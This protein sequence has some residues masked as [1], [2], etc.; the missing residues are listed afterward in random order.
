LAEE[1]RSLDYY[2]GLSV[3]A[4][5]AEIKREE[6]VLEDLGKRVDEIEDTIKTLE[7]AIVRERVSRLE[8]RR[9]IRRETIRKL[10]RDIAEREPKIRAIETAIPELEARARRIDIS[11]TDRHITEREI[12][13]LKRSLARYRWW[14]E[15]KRR[16]LG[17][18]RRWQRERVDLE[19]RLRALNESLANWTRERAEASASITHVR[20]ELEK[21]R[22]A[23]PV[24]K[25]RLVE[26]VKF[27]DVIVRNSAKTPDISFELRGT[28]TIPSG[29]DPA[30][31]R[32]LSVIED[33][34]AGAFAGWG[35]TR[36]V[37]YYQW[38]PAG[39][40]QRYE[41]RYVEGVQR[42]YWFYT[43]TRTIHMENYEQREGTP[44]PKYGEEVAGETDTFISTVTVTIAKYKNKKAL[45][46]QTWT[47]SVTIAEKEFPE[48]PK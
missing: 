12:T 25:F 23:L 30:D 40:G 38:P 13:S 37:A 9:A 43:G 21:K 26:Y 10:E 46:G 3:Q 34:L 31:P 18:Y 20:M 44:Y 39:P 47:T 16:S 35:A 48:V 4:L 2:K 27:F 11:P 33:K 19:T 14:Q 6:G 28:F 42:G 45:K 5:N 22:E 36:K 17:Q 29:L 15:T 7:D 41:P 24:A 1:S 8:E 32:V